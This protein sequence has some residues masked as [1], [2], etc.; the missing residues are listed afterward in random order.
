MA[1]FLLRLIMTKV[2]ARVRL[3]PG[4]GGYFDP[5]SRIH[6]THGEPEKDVLSS[7]NVTNLR[8]AVRNKTISLVTGSLGSSTPAYTLTRN[9]NGKIMLVANSPKTT[10]QTHVN[11]AIK[12]KKVEEKLS[13]ESAVVQE[14]KKIE[15]P[16]TPQQIDNETPQQID[17][18]I[19]QE[20]D[21]DNTPYKT[22]EHE[23]STLTAFIEPII[24]DNFSEQQEPEEIST[25]ENATED[26]SIKPF[27][28]KNKKKGHSA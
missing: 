9:N 20:M 25:E 7:M 27:K 5:I 22:I 14:E 15:E 18:T 24:I 4:K 23:E 17:N 3:N 10:M 13:I 11:P 6:L 12:S 1:I 19:D 28:R 26:E 16:E 2:I 21:N 8:Q